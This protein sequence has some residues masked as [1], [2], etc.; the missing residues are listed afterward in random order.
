MK[1]NSDQNNR[2]FF[3]ELVKFIL[4]V[5]VRNERKS[6][7]KKE[8]KKEEEKGALMLLNNV[9]YEARDTEIRSSRCWY[10]AKQADK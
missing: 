7:A 9:P 1:C 5:I 10:N 2:F 4:K 3:T 8:L 6:E